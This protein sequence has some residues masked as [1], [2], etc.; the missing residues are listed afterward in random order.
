MNTKTVV[1][2]GGG[3]SFRNEREGKEIR[4]IDFARHNKG[5]KWKTKVSERRVRNLG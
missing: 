2:R 3:F 1:S 4:T 5:T